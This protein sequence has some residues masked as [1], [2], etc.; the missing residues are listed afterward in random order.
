MGSVVDSTLARLDLRFGQS[1]H[2]VG[3]KT[4]RNQALKGFICRLAGG[5]TSWVKMKEVY[6]ELRE[7]G[8][9][10]TAAA[11]IKVFFCL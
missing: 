8:P 1:Q 10:G 2:R 6:H 9:C 4:L 5:H 3:G 11:R 7:G